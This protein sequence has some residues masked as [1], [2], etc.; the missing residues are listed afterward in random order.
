MSN[1]KLTYVRRTAG[2]RIL[3]LD[4]A[5]GTSIQKLGLSESDF[6]GN[7]FADHPCDLKGN[8]DIL[9]LT[10]P[11]IIEEIHR[12]FLLAGA[13][14]VET[15]TFNGTAISQRDYHTDHLD[16]DINKAAAEIAR[17]AADDITRQT[18]DRPRFV[19][20]ILGPTSRTTSISP[21]VN[22]PGYRAVTFEDMRRAYYRE[23]EG[24][25]DGGV[26]FLM[27][28]TVFDTLNAKA[29][30]FALT[31][32]LDD[33]S[34]ELPLWISG[35]ITD[36]SGRTLSGQT[37][38]AFWHS[39]SHIDLF[40]AGL[41]CALG[42]AA[43]RPYLQELS[44]VCPTMVSVHPNAGLPNEFGEYD[45][46]PEIMA[47]QIREF[48]ESGFINIV[49]GCCGTT[50]EHISAIAEAVA[51]IAPRKLPTPPSDT[52]LSGLEPLTI[53]P[54]SLFV[55]IG[56]RTNV[57]GSIRFKKLI[58]K[59]DFEKALDIA[60]QQVE[61]GAQVI[62]I[63]MDDAM[64]ESKEAMVEFLNILASDPDIC[65]VPFMIDS[66]RW[67]V[68]EAGLRCLQGK[69]IVNSISLKDGEEQ[70]LE[71][72]RLI[73]HYGAATI[74]M[75]F[76]EQGQADSC[77][78]KVDICTRAYYLLT[79]QVG[80]PPQDIVFDPNIFAVGTGIEEHADY[81]VDYIKACRTIK[82][83]LP[84]TLVSGGVSNLSFSY[85]G[86]DT[87]REAMHSVFL[88]HAIKAGMDMGI[89]NPGQLTVYDEIPRKLRD[90]VE[91]VI[92]NR[93]P[94]ATTRLTE[95]AS[96]TTSAKKSSAKDLS[97]REKTVE[98]R[99]SYSLVHGIVEYIE[100]D[101]LEALK[102]YAQPIRV[103]EGPL[104]DGMSIV[105]DLFGSGKMFLPQ[106]VKSA[107]AMKKS[108][109]VLEPY[110]DAEKMES[111]RAAKGKILLATVKGDVHDIGKN[112]VGIVL[113]CNNYDVI[114]LGVMVPAD[115]ILD[116]AV[117]EHVDIIGLSGLIT[118]SL[119]EMI[120]VASEMQRRKVS[121]PLLIG[122]ATTSRVH[123]AVKIAPAYEGVTVHVAD[124]SRSVGVVSD[125]LS[126]K[127]RD[128]FAGEIKQAYHDIRLTRTDNAPARK[129][130]SLEE[131]RANTL[132]PDWQSYTP[133][134]PKHLG[135]QAFADVDIAELRNYIDWTPFFIAWE[136]PGRYPRIFE[137]EHLGNQ[138]RELFDDANRLLDKIIA[139]KLLTASAV[140]GLFPA[141]AEGDDIRLYYDNTRHEV[142]ATIH[143]L[144]QQ[145]FKAGGKPN[146][147]LS[148]FVAPTES[149]VVDYAGAFAVTAGLG[150]DEAANKF[151]EEQDDYNR[152]MIKIL[153]DRLAEALAER[154]H[155]LVRT[156]YWG[157][158]A[159]EQ[160]TN[161]DIIAERYTG[162]RPAPGYPACPDHSEKT[163]LFDLLKV[164]EHTGIA[165]TES[166]A[167]HPAA[168]VSGWYLAHP[169][170]YYFGVGKIDRD[171]VVDY[172]A[173]KNMEVSV[174]ETWLAPILGYEVPVNDTQA[175]SKSDDVKEKS[176]TL[177][178]QG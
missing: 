169:D 170:S 60:R 90:A 122:G 121:L 142:L 154:M 79:E 89:V 11:D 2:Q 66:S 93:H 116:T 83:T 22:R 27:V 138:P 49:G 92:L 98:E 18:P 114:D 34:L 177:N 39:V 118:P 31:Q 62:D 28:E 7:L 131:A 9:S 140:I 135:V 6:R 94:D 61:N 134:V 120:H 1:S 42:A 26:D 157:Y 133:V 136:L 102:K 47:A 173:R 117:T 63:N 88:Y 23:A 86:N 53:R 73:R 132:T 55:N 82:E 16:Y 15:N 50:P 78:R 128:D 119:D 145:K 166:C 108:V 70:F 176:S 58:K 91:D 56:E 64:L 156:T 85:R 3:I 167:M 21:D 40:C 59:G 44:R 41:N 160:L 84:G 96:Q 137:Y 113:S 99:L 72:A 48:A 124:A 24:L 151:A 152:I 158:A 77:Q 101:T 143:G 51:D 37:T 10:R 71:K 36:Q 20:G 32:V 54:D 164:T 162:I 57:A 149:G 174:V 146:V 150:A 13:D 125:L 130:L 43:L 104:M 8:N 147:C 109:A 74:V 144:R 111:S 175:A 172:A 69:G 161:E 159:D 115:K 17:R 52:R 45:D 106:V 95:I 148:D 14:I 168:S 112:I 80:F 65:R 127:R 165:L 67:E 105:G 129:L 25:I 35:T 75:A 163:T 46:T 153:A 107:R 87:V 155:H 178:K 12:A 100:R 171:Q 33:R 4:G 29:A 103:I 30:L 110:L 76:D 81:A 139:E 123:T 68:I 97:W 5:M 19:A 38:E 126:E 141:N